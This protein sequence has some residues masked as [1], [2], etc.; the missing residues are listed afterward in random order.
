VGRPVSKLTALEELDVALRNAARDAQPDETSRQ[1]A[2]QFCES[3][4]RLIEAFRAEWVIEK[5]AV[6]IGKH[7]AKV[8]RESQPQLVFEGLLGFRRLPRTIEIEPGKKVRRGDATIGV[9]RTLVSQ[10][11]DRESPALKEANQAIA[12][13]AQYTPTEPRIT[14]AEVAEREAAKAIAQRPGP[15]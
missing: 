11:R 6:L 14:W 9:F 12:L 4:R 15:A 10:L 5:V 13:M 3:E 7:R 8:R 1:I 2:E